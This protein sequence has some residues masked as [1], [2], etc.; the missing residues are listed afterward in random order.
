[1][2][3]NDQLQAKYH[4]HKIFLSIVANWDDLF[5]SNVMW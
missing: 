5:V 2:T 1:M 3:L 4:H